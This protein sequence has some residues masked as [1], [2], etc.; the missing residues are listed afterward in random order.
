MRMTGIDQRK[1]LRTVPAQSKCILNAPCGFHNVT[2]LASGGGATCAVGFWGTKE[3]EWEEESL[4]SPHGVACTFM[5]VDN[6]LLVLT[7][8]PCKVGVTV[9][10][11]K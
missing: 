4:L 9:F 8:P 1:A 2:L 6:L 5:M 3:G 10:L 7:T 11:C